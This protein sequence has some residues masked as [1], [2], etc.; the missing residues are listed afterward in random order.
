MSGLRVLHVSAYFAPAFVYGGPPR[1]ILGLCRALR[2][3]GVDV[4]VMTTTANGPNATLEPAVERPRIVDGVPVRYF[5]IAEPRWLWHAP[6][7][8]DAVQRD[9]PAYDVVHV[10]GLWHLPAWHA[11]RAAR[12]YDVPYVV[13][14]RGMLEPQALALRHTRK[15]IAFRLVEQR[16]LKRAATLHAT[17][18]Q[19]SATLER[20]RLGPPILL[21]PNGVDID[22]VTSANPALVLRALGLSPD[23]RFVLFLGR[24]HPIKRLDLLAAAMTHLRTR[25]ISIVVAGPDEGG[26]R[27][28][29]APLFEASGVRTIWTGPVD[30]DRKAALLTA[31]RALVVC[32]DS[33]SFGLTVAEAMAA[34]TP[35]VVTR[36]C[37][38]A[39]IEPEG[40]G[41]WVEQTA[42]AI[43]D[44]V[45]RVL[46]DE[47]AA[48]AMGARGRAVVERRYTWAE[49]ARLLARCYEGL[50]A[51]RAY[52]AFDR[53]AGAPGVSKAG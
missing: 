39:E 13:S 48:R 2:S 9:T 32:S 46:S 4:E 33:E 3:A 25:D 15:A 14:P 47:Q 17:S 1:S 51:R 38:W 45:D 20:R 23:E 8:R 31:A 18:S 24:I 29:I 22:R 12:R 42:P 41:Y 43:A 21:A 44:A 50:A 35:V 28:T 11:A 40:A 36:T 37:P 5:P 6:Q 7:L 27:E 19:E 49:S 53:G 34:A 52:H 26:H 30:D 16:N 10:H